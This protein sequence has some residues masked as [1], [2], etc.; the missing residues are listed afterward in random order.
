MS[1]SCLKH[2]Q[3]MPK[4]CPNDTQNMSG[5][6]PKHVWMIPKTFQ[7][8]QF[9][10]WKTNLF[11]EKPIYFLKN[12]LIFWKT[13]LFF[14][15]PFIFWKINS[16]FEK[17]LYFL[18]NQPKGINS[19]P[20]GDNPHAACPSRPRWAPREHDPTHSQPRSILDPKFRPSLD[21]V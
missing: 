12:Q 21:K 20:T 6:N 13:N 5:W 9:N 16:F 19:T 17:S 15:N 11:L 8:N 2:V 4:T 7:K 3:I 14:E 18:K 1:K 10:F